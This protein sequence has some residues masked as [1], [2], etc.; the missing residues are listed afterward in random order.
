MKKT[1][2]KLLIQFIHGKLSAI[3]VSGSSS[4]EWESESFILESSQL[5]SE[6]C[7]IP[8]KLNFKG[9][10]VSFGA[11]T[12]AIDFILLKIQPLKP[13][14][15]EMFLERKA[16]TAKG[17]THI[18]GYTSIKVSGKEDT[19]YLHLVPEV[20]RQVF[21]DFCT[22]FGYQ[23]MM[24][25]T[26]AAIAPELLTL[27]KDNQIEMVVAAGGESTFIVV[28]RKNHP[29]LI[30]EVPYGWY[31]NGDGNLER[32]G[33]EIQ[34]T[35]LFTKQQYNRAV[36]EIR[37]IGQNSQ[38]V[39]DL[40]GDIADV[41]K[42]AINENVNWC[43]FT[44]NMNPF[45]KDNLLPRKLIGLNK[46]RKYLI[47]IAITV[48]L[49][50][51][52][53]FAIEVSY[54]KMKFDTEK[55]IVE[56]GIETSID[57]L[58]SIRQALETKKTEMIQNQIRDDFIKK[59]NNDPVP[60]W[61]ANCVADNIP[62]DLNLSRMMIT[63]DSTDGNWFIQIEGFAPRNPV[64]ASQ[65]LDTFENRLKKEPSLFQPEIPWKIQWIDNLQ[66]GS[67]LETAI[68]GKVFRIQGRLK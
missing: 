44:L 39:S 59:L 51:L 65:L 68:K 27:E 38:I 37:F 35:V 26:L 1:N 7:L 14:E 16:H 49:I 62:N 63:R 47:Y 45:R 54:L 60:G 3:V 43:K 11:A 13:A 50:V 53:S 20:Y 24:L 33:R 34:R 30:R 48:L 31:N 32:L 64:I 41:K 17:N 6:M 21:L 58:K 10:E 61:F 22:K 29:L 40:A 9:E 5:Y 4:R 52:F 19:I 15:L 36:Q 18:F 8:K 42:T 55:S 28:G 67:T 25:M 23:P 66:Q 56:S 57:S 2:E 12:P 46:K